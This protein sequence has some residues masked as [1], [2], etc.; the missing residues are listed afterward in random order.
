MR[1]QNFRDREILLAGELLRL[2]N[3]PEAK[4]GLEATVTPA[5]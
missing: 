3:V 4:F 5:P 2:W 1:R